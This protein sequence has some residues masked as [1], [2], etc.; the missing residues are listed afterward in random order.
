MDGIVLLLQVK[1]S[2]MNLKQSHTEYKFIIV[3]FYHL[4]RHIHKGLYGNFIIDPKMP[5][6]PALE[7]NMVMNGI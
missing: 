4:A 3:M 6:E 5:R 1:H 7:L 2:L